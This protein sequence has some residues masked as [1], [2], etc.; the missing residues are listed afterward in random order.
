M[1]H[2][3]FSENFDW[4][5]V[6][7]YRI[8]L[9]TVRDRPHFIDQSIKISM[10]VFGQTIF[11]MGWRYYYAHFLH[12]LPRIWNLGAAACELF[13]YFIVYRFR[14]VSAASQNCCANIN[15]CQ[16]LILYSHWISIE[17]VFSVSWSLFFYCFFFHSVRL[18][19]IKANRHIQNT[20]CNLKW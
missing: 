10:S 9:N 5:T 7:N 14:A 2:T 1:C 6:K 13:M 4:K 19:S 20:M 12:I 11:D 8:N 16:N 15:F 18:I 3:Y 17:Q